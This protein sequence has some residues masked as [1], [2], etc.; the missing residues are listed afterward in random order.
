MLKREWKL[1]VRHP[2]LSKE[3]GWLLRELLWEQ[4]LRLEGKSLQV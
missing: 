1:E 3:K 2:E 4:W